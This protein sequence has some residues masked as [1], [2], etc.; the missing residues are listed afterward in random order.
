MTA[1][2]QRMLE[3]MQVRQLSPHTQRAYIANVARFARHVGRYPAELGPEEI[4]TYQLYL[5][6]VHRP[7]SSEH[8]NDPT[9]SRPDRKRGWPTALGHAI[10]DVARDRRFGFLGHGMSSA[11]PTANDRLVPEEG[12]F[13]ASLPVVALLLL[14]PAAPD[15][16]DPQNGVIASACPGSPPRHS[17]GFRRWHHDRRAT[18]TRGLVDRDRVVGSISSDA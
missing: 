1:L 10:Q 4:R 11:K 12:V 5:A 6:L 8:R 13:H 9:T 2:R 17:G 16:L 3:D 7:K 14:P 18:A 15:L